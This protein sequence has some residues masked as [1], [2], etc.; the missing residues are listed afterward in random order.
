MTRTDK[1]ESGFGAVEG[2]LITVIVV[3]IGSV[4]WYTWHVRETTSKY[5]KPVTTQVKKQ[6]ADNI[7]A[8]T[9]KKETVTTPAP[10]DGVVTFIAMVT[11]DG[12]A[13]PSG[14]QA[15]A[16]DVGCSIVVGDAVINIVRGNT[17]VKEWGSLIGFKSPTDITGKLVEVHA[18]LNS[19]NHFS[20]SRSDSYVKLLN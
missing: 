14:T 3:L 11:E 4:G 20:L 19:S 1:A 6:T 8:P 9:T 15:P 7:P 13:A 16:G 2:L 12:C 5:L 18:V 10:A 17:A